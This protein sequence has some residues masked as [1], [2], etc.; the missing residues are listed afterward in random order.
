MRLCPLLQCR[1]AINDFPVAYHRVVCFLHFE[2]YWS[3]WSVIF[4]T[5]L[6]LLHILSFFSSLF[7]ILKLQHSTSKQRVYSVLWGTLL[8]DF[9][10][11][12]DSKTS[13]TPRLT[14]EVL[15][16]SEWDGQGR[17]SNSY[18]NGL[19]L[20]THTGKEHSID[21]FYLSVSLSLTHSVYIM[22]LRMYL[23]TLN[24]S[25]PISIVIMLSLFCYP[26][27]P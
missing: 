1:L 23:F 25:L 6:A 7:C 15:G 22:S 14:S 9:D 12:E 18:P 8:L 5:P 10:S 20:V 3:I 11:E 21:A 4:E 17:G 2:N 16:I 24:L 27:F 13:L 26:S 19:L